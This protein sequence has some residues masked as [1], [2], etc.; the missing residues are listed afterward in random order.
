MKQISVVKTVLKLALVSVASLLVACGGSSSSSDSIDASISG[1]IFAAPVS[2]ADVSV[3]AVSGAPVAGPVLTDAAGQYTLTIP[4]GSLG[5]DLIVK[6]TGGAFID[7]ATGGA[8]NTGNGGTISDSGMF[9]YVSANSISNGSSV[10]V[11]PGST[12]I[13][14]LAMNHGVS[15][16]QAETNFFK[17]F[18]YVPDISVTPVDATVPA[19]GASDASKLAGLRAA[20]FSQLAQDLGLSQ[21]DQ[22]IMFI[23]LA[24][25][26]SDGMLNGLMAG[27]GIDIDSPTLGIKTLPLDIVKRSANALLDFQTG[28][29]SRMNLTSNYRI[30]YVPGMMSAMAGKSAFTFRIANRSDGSDAS[31]LAATVMPMMYMETMNHSTPLTDV[32][33]NGDGTYAATIYYLMPSGMN[34]MSMGYWDLGVTVGNE[35]VHFYPN[36]MMSMGDTF[37]VVLN[38]V[39]DKIMTMDEV[40]VSRDYPI[41]K[42]SL[43]GGMG[44]YDFSVFVSAKE[45]MESFSAVIEGNTLQSGMMGMGTPLDVDTVLVEIS[46][47]DGLSWNPATD[48]L[49]GTWSITGLSLTDG[50]EDQIRV[51]LTVNGEVKTAGGLT[52]D[53]D[54]QTFTVTPGS[55]GMG[56]M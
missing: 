13:A 14:H 34:G 26:L 27:E 20:A 43:T 2:G 32:I 42:E 48:G 55:S 9:A 7:E 29:Y 11:T 35:T 16:E 4:A 54:Y 18:G 21:N 41:F 33:D 1:T 31:G 23:A 52:G 3:V 8:T 40:M 17:G 39:N 53:P 47:D 51:R 6:A 25:D 15:I 50:V 24:Q 44:S 36:V 22:F 56:G 10:S 28:G 5:Q 12:I 30:E 49:D 19:V 37:K 45:H 46:D 38:G